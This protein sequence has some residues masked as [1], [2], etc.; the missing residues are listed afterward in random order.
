MEIDVDLPPHMCDKEKKLRRNKFF[1]ELITP[2]LIRCQCG[3]Q[4][5]LDRAYRDKNLRIHVKSNSCQ[6]R[7]NGQVS[8]LKYFSKTSVQQSAEQ[9]SK[10]CIGLTNEK[11]ENYVIKSPSEFGGS[12]KDYEI[13][14]KLFPNKFP[15]NS[16]FS[17]S[18]L[19][20]EELQQLKTTLR[21]EGYPCHKYRLTIL[22]LSLLRV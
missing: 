11:I 1:L 7:S 5:K 14:K 15:E 13:A 19:I 4:I 12:K 20:S 2:K 21:T 9:N 10:A 17:Y 18:Q 16:K 22:Q 8:V 6:A 3:K